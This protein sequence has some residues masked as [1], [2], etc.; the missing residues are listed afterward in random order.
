VDW[1]S[2]A[3]GLIGA[4][5]GAAAAIGGILLNNFFERRRLDSDKFDAQQVASRALRD[6]FYER[7]SRIADALGS[8]RY[9]LLGLRDGDLGDKASFFNIA[10]GLLGSKEW[11]GVA[12]A[13]RECINLETRVGGGDVPST[14]ELKRLY[15]RLQ[16]SRE[17]LAVLDPDWGADLHRRHE[18]VGERPEEFCKIDAA[19]ERNTILKS[20]SG[21]ERRRL[22]KRLVPRNSLNN[23]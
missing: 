23:G 1:L 7:Q 22:K 8:G 11:S 12:K 4:A 19:A 13:R 5:L 17:V 2:G 20:R 10:E 18:K 16:R 14:Q 6:D 21:W 9:V 15:W 3:S